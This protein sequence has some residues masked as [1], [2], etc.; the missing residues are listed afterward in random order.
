MSIFKGTG[1]SQPG[2]VRSLGTKP[3]AHSSRVYPGSQKRAAQNRPGAFANKR[4]PPRSFRTRIPV[5]LTPT[6]HALLKP[7]ELL[8]VD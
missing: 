2:Y 8:A 6:G 7:L 4:S 1:D 5:N 3:E